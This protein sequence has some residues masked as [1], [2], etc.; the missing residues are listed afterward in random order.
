MNRLIA[1]AIEQAHQLGT[2]GAPFPDDDVVLIVRAQGARLVDREMPVETS[3]ARPRKHLRNNGTT[4]T[5]VVRPVRP[6][7]VPDPAHNARFDA[8]A[9]L[10]TLKSFL[11]AN[12]IRSTNSTSGIDWCSSNNSTPCAVGH[13]SVPVLVAAMGGNTGLRDN[14]MVYEMATSRDKDFVIV[15]GATHNIAPCTE[16]ETRPGQYSNSTR[17]FF[18]YVARWMRGRF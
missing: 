16:C 18:N 14:E 11:S 17:N 13:I 6:P 10:L 15:E 7:V 2:S 9:R 1:T 5:E 8:G 12:A 4:T 3:T